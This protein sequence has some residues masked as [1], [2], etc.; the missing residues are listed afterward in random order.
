MNLV[1]LNAS[2]NPEDEF[3][4][5]E[6]SDDESDDG[7]DGTATNLEGKLDKKEA[8]LMQLVGTS[9]VSSFTA[10]SCHPDKLAMVP[11]TL[12]DHNQFLVCLYHCEKDALIIGCTTISYA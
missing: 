3:L 2:E 11:T 7:S 1:W 12:I 9:V 8:N 10:K 4:V 6:G 5:T